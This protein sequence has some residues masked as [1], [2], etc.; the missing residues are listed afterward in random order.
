MKRKRAAK[1]F[2]EDKFKQS[3]DALGLEDWLKEV[4]GAKLLEAIFS[5]LS[6]K[7]VEYRKTKHSVAITKWL[8]ENKPE[9]F[10]ELRLFL[11]GVLQRNA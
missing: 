6:G 10:D 5:R 3:E 7:T 8:V 11:H 9:H 4:H 1:E 2:L